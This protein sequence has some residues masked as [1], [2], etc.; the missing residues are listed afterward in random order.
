MWARGVY[1]LVLNNAGSHLAP[2]HWGNHCFGV[3][4][5][6]LGIILGIWGL[7]GAVVLRNG[8]INTIGMW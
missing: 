3:L 5:G 2:Q 8:F 4:L 1:H 7:L 6:N